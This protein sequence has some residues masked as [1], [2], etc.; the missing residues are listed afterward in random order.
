MSW[1]VL[2]FEESKRNFKRVYRRKLL[3]AKQVN[4]PYELDSGSC[5]EFTLDRATS[6][7]EDLIIDS[8]GERSV[9]RIRR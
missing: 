4:S 7:L 2:H 8:A 1:T 5:T 6:V 9:R 3:N